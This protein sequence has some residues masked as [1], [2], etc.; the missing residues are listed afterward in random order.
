M[1]RILASDKL[2]DEG[3]RILKDEKQFSVEVKTGL[4]ADELKKIF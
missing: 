3:L 2:S 4:S 1:I